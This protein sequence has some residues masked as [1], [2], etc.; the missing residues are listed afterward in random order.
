MV[1][2]KK[3]PGQAWMGGAKLLNL[4][5]SVRSYNH[6]MLYLEQ[7]FL[8]LQCCSRH[9]RQSFACF[10]WTNLSSWSRS[11]NESHSSALYR[12]SSLI[13][14]TRCEQKLTHESR[15]QLRRR[16]PERQRAEAARPGMILATRTINCPCSV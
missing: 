12:T 11:R 4:T 2:S 3:V 6:V 5:Q 16:Y 15:Q 8:E 1:T 10:A 9:F 13:I 7:F 14:Q